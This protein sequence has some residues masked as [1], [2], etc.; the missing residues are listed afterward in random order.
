MANAEVKVEKSN[1]DT[2][3]RK[4]RGGNVLREACSNCGCRRYTDCTCMK[5]AK[6]S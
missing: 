1:V 5:K 3:L 6:V 2:G 4:L